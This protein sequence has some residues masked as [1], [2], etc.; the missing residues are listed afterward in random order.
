MRIIRLTN[1]ACLDR[2]SR[3]GDFAL[4]REGRVHPE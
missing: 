3:P 2:T 1:A 4:S